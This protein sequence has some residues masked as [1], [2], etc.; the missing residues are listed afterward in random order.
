MKRYLFLLFVLLFVFFFAG[1]QV[2][3]TFFKPN[4]AVLTKNPVVVYETYVSPANIKQIRSSVVMGTWNGKLYIVPSKGEGIVGTKYQN[5]LCAFEDGSLLTCF[6]LRKAGCFAKYIRG[7]TVYFTS[8]QSPG[9][10]YS[11]SIA[12]ETLK[13]LFSLD[14]LPDPQFRIFARNMFFREDG[15]VFFSVI[16]FSEPERWHVRVGGDKAV[17]CEDATETYALGGMTY[18]MREEYNEDFVYR[19]DAEGHAEKLPL[20][21]AHERSIICTDRELLIHNMESS[22]RGVMLY[23]VTEDGDLIELFA[24]PQLSSASAV[25]VYYD[26]VYFSFMRTEK[27]GSIGMLGFENDD[28]IGTWRISLTDYSAEKLSDKV[29][30]GLYIFDDTGIYACDCYCDLYKLD[31][32]GKVI[33]TLMEVIR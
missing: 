5:Q 24:A 20:E 1:M 7:D 18:Y 32:D 29:Y 4:K 25:T 13:E 12:E 22:G 23:Y 6:D 26:T 11:Y 3:I 31:F 2:Y 10:L 15:S 16:H 17:S 8:D 30:D 19:M 21:P 27:Y 33:E 14:S 9:K 28:M